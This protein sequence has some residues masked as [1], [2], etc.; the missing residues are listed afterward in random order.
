MNRKRQSKIKKFLDNQPTV[1]CRGLCHGSCTVIGMTPTEFVQLT[2]VSGK[3]PKVT[4]DMK[5]NYLVDNRCSVY[6]YRPMVCRQFGTT[7]RLPCP[8]GCVPSRLMT[9]VEGYEQLRKFSELCGDDPYAVKYNGTRK[10]IYDNYIAEGIPADI[11]QSMLPPLNHEENQELC[12]SIINQM[13][14]S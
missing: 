3:E 9:E 5:C 13:R 1:A 11:A 2:R 12:E 4:P 14:K 6:E 8:Y 10:Q 7:E